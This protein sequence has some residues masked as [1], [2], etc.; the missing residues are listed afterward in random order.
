MYGEMYNREEFEKEVGM[1]PEL[2]AW[3]DQVD[4]YYAQSPWYN[5]FSI[6]G[7]VKQFREEWRY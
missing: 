5:S 3:Y 2:S 6:S 4:R 7:I 1:T